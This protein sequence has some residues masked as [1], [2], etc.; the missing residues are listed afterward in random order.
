[1]WIYLLTL[2]LF[3]AHLKIL[4]VTSDLLYHALVYIFN[5]FKILLNT[6][7]ISYIICIIEMHYKYCVA[8]TQQLKLWHSVSP[9]K[10][11]AGVAAQQQPNCCDTSHNHIY[12][13]QPQHKVLTSIS[14]CFLITFTSTLLKTKLYFDSCVFFCVYMC[15]CL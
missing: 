13:H 12:S 5:H 15:A 2:T 4:Y 1:M 11:G 14:G 6:A 10:V 3:A 9:T 8:S 7:I